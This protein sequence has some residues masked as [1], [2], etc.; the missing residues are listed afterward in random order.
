MKKS[1]TSQRWLDEHEQDP[2]VLKGAIG[3]L[4]L[5]GSL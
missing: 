4:S 1:K 3:G 2:Y 5:S